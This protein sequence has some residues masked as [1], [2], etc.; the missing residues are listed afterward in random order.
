M[1]EFN[2]FLFFLLA[3]QFMGVTVP[4]MKETAGERIFSRTGTMVVACCEKMTR[5]MGN[6]PKEDIEFLIRDRPVQCTQIAPYRR[7]LARNEE[8]YRRIGMI[9]L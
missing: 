4:L 1:F 8:S 6:G 3:I 5:F 2:V 7:F 9:L